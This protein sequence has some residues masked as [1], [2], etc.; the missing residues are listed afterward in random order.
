MRNKKINEFETTEYN[1]ISA[2][3]E[4]I[5]PDFPIKYDQPRTPVSQ[6]NQHQYQQ[7]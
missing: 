6:T 5:I 3:S 7:A 1:K 2:A 4:K